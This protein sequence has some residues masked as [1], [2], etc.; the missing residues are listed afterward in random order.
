MNEIL[1]KI[2]GADLVFL[3]LCALVT[4]AFVV[5]RVCAVFEPADAVDEDEIADRI[6]DAIRSATGDLLDALGGANASLD[7]IVE[8]NA[9]LEQSEREARRASS[10]WLDTL[11]PH[12]FRPAETTPP[13]AGSSDLPVD[14]TKRDA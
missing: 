7:K 4:F 8:S 9:Y 6:E 2:D 1:N 3:A 12:G 10:E 5:H 14:L 13:Y 11:R